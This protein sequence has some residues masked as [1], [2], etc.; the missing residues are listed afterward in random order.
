M[1]SIQPV[2]IFNITQPQSNIGWDAGIARFA[3]PQP[4]CMNGG[5][6]RI[7]TTL[8]EARKVSLEATFSRTNT[9]CLQASVSTPT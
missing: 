1:D 6:N 8:D 4:H 9:G 7:I 3:R 2:V 5:N